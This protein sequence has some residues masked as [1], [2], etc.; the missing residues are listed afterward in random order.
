MDQQTQ[1]MKCRQ[2]ETTNPLVYTEP[3]NGSC[4]CLDCGEKTKQDVA[5]N[6]L[7]A[8]GWKV[9]DFSGGTVFLTRGEGKTSVKSTGKIAPP[10]W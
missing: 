4:L 6:K 7:L 8:T 3:N 2:C 9:Y 1:N 10:P 5:V